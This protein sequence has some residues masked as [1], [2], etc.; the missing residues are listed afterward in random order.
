MSSVGRC[1]RHDRDLKHRR[2]GHQRKSPRQIRKGPDLRKFS[3]QNDMNGLIA[4]LF[5]VAFVPTK[6]GLGIYIYC[7]L[8]G[9]DLTVLV[10]SRF[11]C[12]ALRA[13][14]DQCTT[15]RVLPST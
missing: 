6:L 3:A 12:G 7:I 10:T 9:M 2:E 15:I 13:T 14:A 5:Y 8:I 11:T 1:A 4:K